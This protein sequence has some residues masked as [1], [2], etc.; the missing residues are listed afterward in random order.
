MLNCPTYWKKTH[1]AGIP[2]TVSSNKRKS[3]LEGNLGM[4]GSHSSYFIDEITEFGLN[5][6][7]FSKLGSPLVGWRGRCVFTLNFIS[8]DPQ[9]ANSVD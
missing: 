4:N 8:F 3:E 9:H 2:A 5:K 7:M 6:C 1:Q